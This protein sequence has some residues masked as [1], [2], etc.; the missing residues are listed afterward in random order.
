MSKMMAP[1]AERTV[2]APQP[3]VAQ[4]ARMLEAVR[5]SDPGGLI[6]R[7]TSPLTLLRDGPYHV[8]YSPFDTVN[9]Q[10]EVVLVGVTPGP[11]QH[12]EAIKALRRKLRAGWSAEEAEAAAK[13][14]GAFQGRIR[15]PL[16]RMLDFIRLPE[17]LGYAR[18]GH[19]LSQGADRLHLTSALRYPVF[20]R[21]GTQGYPGDPR[22]VRRDWMRA[23]VEQL[24]GAELESLPRAWVFPL[25][26]NASRAVAHLARRGAVDPCR[27]FHGLQ[28]PS[29]Q[30]GQC[31]KPFLDPS[32]ASD[33]PTKMARVAEDRARI[34]QEM[35]KRWPLVSAPT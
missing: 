8:E 30:N 21:G 3:G 7:R 29:P 10:A 18:A 31:W 24:L 23:M 28:H 34:L 22:L 20:K 33:A 35:E 17:R 16:C 27:V 2:V 5:V 12:A 11:D 15:D 26:P 1:G 32:T 4:K 14:A 6:Q 13:A 19:L 9:P 25:G